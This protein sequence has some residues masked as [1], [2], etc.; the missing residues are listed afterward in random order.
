MNINTTN[1]NNRMPGGEMRSS[2][3][4]LMT[5]SCTRRRPYRMSPAARRP[6]SGG[7]L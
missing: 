6:L 2:G 1:Q 7:L 3:T 4:P 5:V